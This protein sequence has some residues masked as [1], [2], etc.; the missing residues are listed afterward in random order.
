MPH[1]LTQGLKPLAESY[2]PFGAK[3][4]WSSCRKTP[5]FSN[6]VRPDRSGVKLP[7]NRRTRGY[8]RYA[9]RRICRYLQACFLTPASDWS[10][11][12]DKTT[13]KNQ[14]EERI[15]Y[16]ISQKKARDAN[17]R[18]TTRNCAPKTHAETFPGTQRRQSARNHQPS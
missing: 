4:K 8:P 1:Y 18:A 15:E 9:K 5:R 17:E 7:K 6:L 3:T 16:A 11:S 12:T 14:L 13:I 10:I 2:C